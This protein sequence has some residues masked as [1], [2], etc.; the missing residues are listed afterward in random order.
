MKPVSYPV[1]SQQDAWP[2][3]RVAIVGVVQPRTVLQ[4]GPLKL[5]R[6]PLR[7]LLQ[8]ILHEIRVMCA[9]NILP[10]LGTVII[11]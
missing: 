1:H 6:F 9:A 8:V 7:A 4:P 11:G 10:V 5:A 2:S 3:L